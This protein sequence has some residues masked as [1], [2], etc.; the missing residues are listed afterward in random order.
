MLSSEPADRTK[1]W[2]D[3]DQIAT[4]EVTSEDSG[5]TI[6]SAF[7]ANGGPGWRASKKGEQRIHQTPISALSAAE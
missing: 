1:A 6:E 4:I 3:L 2:L 7:G 5:F